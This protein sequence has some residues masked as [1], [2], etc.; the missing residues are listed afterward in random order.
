MSRALIMLFL[1]IVMTAFMTGVGETEALSAM[2]GQMMAVNLRDR[3]AALC[4]QFWPT[5]VIVAFL[6]DPA[7]DGLAKAVTGE[8]D[9]APVADEA[10]HAA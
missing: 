10:A 3:F 8:K 1:G 9:P 7:A 5:I 4:L 2:T 6:C